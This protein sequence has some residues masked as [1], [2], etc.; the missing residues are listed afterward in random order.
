MIP[1][2]GHKDRKKIQV[3]KVLG[4]ASI[5]SRRLGAAVPSKVFQQRNHRLPDHVET[6]LSLK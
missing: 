2:A 3:V 6:T 4:Q 1:S 5:W